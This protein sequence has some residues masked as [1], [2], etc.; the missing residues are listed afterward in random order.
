MLYQMYVPPLSSTQLPLADT[1]HSAN[2]ISPNSSRFP[3]SFFYYIFIPCDIIS[4]I[5]QA[6]GGAMSATS[7]G[8]NQSGV[9]I[10]L[11]GLAFQVF[12]LVAF[13]IAVLD[14]MWLSR[15]VWRNMQLGWRFKSFAV[16]LT[17]ATVLILIRCCY[18]CCRRSTYEGKNR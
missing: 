1:T 6:V 11:A 14:Y 10:A 13:I 17:A 16:F 8:G 15:R 9:N 5:L 7:N 18:V 12:T 4:L 3:P 2:Y